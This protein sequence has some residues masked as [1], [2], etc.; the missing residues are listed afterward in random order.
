MGN[1]KYYSCFKQG[2]IA[3]KC[4]ATYTVFILYI[5]CL[6]TIF[7][8]YINQKYIPGKHLSFNKHCDV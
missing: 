7:Q 5:Y 1:L 6:L 4:F 3:K 8:D 2:W